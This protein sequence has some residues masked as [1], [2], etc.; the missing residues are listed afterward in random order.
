MKTFLICFGFILVILLAVLCVI[1]MVLSL[2]SGNYI[3]CVLCAVGS[4]ATIAFGMT[5]MIKGVKYIY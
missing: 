5:L 1:G 4:A 2:L 3:L